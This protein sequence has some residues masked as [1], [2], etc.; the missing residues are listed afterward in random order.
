M[1]NKFK[2]ISLITTSLLVSACSSMPSTPNGFIK[3]NIEAK[4]LNFVVWEKENIAQNET[5]RFY[6]EG[7]GTP[8]PNKAIALELAK[9]DQTNNIIVLTRPCQYIENKICQN[10]NIW[11][12]ERYHPEILTEM[13]ELTN[14][15]IKKYKAKNVEF[16]AYDDAAPI[17]FNLAQRLGG[18]KKIVTIA[19]V[20]DINSYAKQNNLPKFKNTK[21]IQYNQHIIERIPQ[22]HYIG[23]DDT[24]V[25]RSMTEKF[26]SKFNNP[27][28]ITIKVVHGFDH[29]DWDKIKLSY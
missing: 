8:N 27:K 29:D 15:F 4:Q 1:K 12:T 11:T 16:V 22:I 21:E 25:T 5:L 14:F 17:A 9:E 24:V 18:A 19:G 3:K 26:V 7:N 28:N 20:L 6:I 23:S 2:L 10:K 13:K